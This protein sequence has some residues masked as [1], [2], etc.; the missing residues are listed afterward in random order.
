MVDARHCNLSNANALMTSPGARATLYATLSLSL[1]SATGEACM[2]SLCCM[3][4]HFAC[5]C[6]CA[7]FLL[8]LL[9][10]RRLLLLLLRTPALLPS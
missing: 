10:R 5:L 2:S 6:A 7:H 8:L 1:T 9:L 3:H 4:P